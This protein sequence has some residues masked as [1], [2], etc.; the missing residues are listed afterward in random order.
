[1]ILGKEKDLEQ[2]TKRVK[3]Y[4]NIKTMLFLDF[5][6]QKRLYKYMRNEIMPELSNIDLKD[7]KKMISDIFRGVNKAIK[8]DVDTACKEIIAHLHKKLEI[9]I[10]EQVL[11]QSFLINPDIINKEGQ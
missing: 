10:I 2:I 9:E 5:R 7:Q 3:N 4:L 1:M 6:L 8:K 11:F